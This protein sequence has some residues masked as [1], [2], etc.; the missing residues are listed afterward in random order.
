MKSQI[1]VERGFDVGCFKSQGLDGRGMADHVISCAWATEAKPE[2]AEVRAWRDKAG[3]S[4]WPEGP[5]G[6][7]RRKWKRFGSHLQ[8]DVSMSM[9]PV[10]ASCPPPS[11]IGCKH[12]IPSIPSLPNI[13]TSNFCCSTLYWGNDCSSRLP[14]LRVTFLRAASTR[15]FSG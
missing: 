9:S 11:I 15:P 2:T 4:V 6:S 8:S 5:L 12:P 10:P 3:A 14:K 1:L 7:F 13:P